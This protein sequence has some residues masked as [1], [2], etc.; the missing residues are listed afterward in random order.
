MSRTFFKTPIFATYG[1]LAIGLASLAIC[2]IFF[3]DNEPW[4]AVFFAG[5]SIVAIIAFLECYTSYIELEEG[6]ICFRSKFATRR[7][8]KTAIEKVTWEKGTGVSVRLTDGNWVQMPEL[9]QNSQGLSNSMR[10]WL[11]S[12]DR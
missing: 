7:L 10:A 5:F 9:F 11:G 8:S 12:E 1:S 3:K 2:Y 4:L 6:A